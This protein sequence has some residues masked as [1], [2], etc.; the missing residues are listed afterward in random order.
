MTTL[1]NDNYAYN[2]MLK[3][4]S[5]KSRNT[6]TS[7]SK[8]KANEGAS[9]EEPITESEL[10]IYQTFKRINVLS[11]NSVKLKYL[12]L[13]FI[14]SSFS[15]FFE[16]A[17]LG[18]IIPLLQLAIGE[19]ISGGSL[20]TLLNIYSKFGIAESKIQLV[21][22]T[23]LL[24]L[25]S[26]ILKNVFS[27]ISKV[28]ISTMS[29]RVEHN[30]RTNI[31]AQLLKY[32]LLYFERSQIGNMSF[33]LERTK[34]L[35][36][37]IRTLSD[38]IEKL[39]MSVFY[40]GLMLYISWT[41]SLLM[42]LV[43]PIGYVVTKTIKKMVQNSS[44]REAGALRDI[45]NH[46]LR[47]FYSIGLIK[48]Y[49]TE[50]EE[51]NAFEKISRGVSETKIRANRI[52]SLAPVIQEPLV[53]LLVIL[54]AGVSYLLFINGFK[55]A[56][57]GFM[58]FFVVL[59]RFET[60]FQQIPPSLINLSRQKVMVASILKVF[61]S[62]PWM[63]IKSG[64]K[65]FKGIKKNFE[66]KNLSFRY[67]KNDPLVLQDINLKIKAGTTVAF[68]GETGSGKTTLISLLPRSFDYH[69]GEIL[70]DGVSLKKFD[71]R[72]LRHHFGIVRQNDVMFNM[73]FR[74][75]IVYGIKRKVS[76]KELITATKRAQIYD[77]I[78]S[79]KGGFNSMIG[80][81]GAD[82]SGGQRQRVSIARAIIRNS[83]ILI[84]DEATSALDSET[85]D[86]LQ[87]ALKEVFKGKTVFVVA[88]RLSTIQKA[89]V[90]VV[91]NKGR[92][93]EKGSFKQ[94]MKNQ[95]HFFHYWNLQ[96]RA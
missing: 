50:K 38:A 87:V 5:G 74:E 56:V 12:T 83:P 9:K 45:S 10:S 24:I 96:T 4:K 29:S 55:G 67:G 62:E 44:N 35:S 82:L 39:I 68:V 43:V 2:Y 15:S 76:E 59:K 92:I 36:Q 72:S 46:S 6:K 14:L 70:V 19:E 81:S 54:M 69:S 57:A 48:S 88:H 49:G 20:N 65:G 26:V 86:K 47:I 85:E 37:M 63:K 64:K 78:M 90:I 16:I 25:L 61:D 52:I 21:L 13:P 60:T 3:A 80:E 93:V 7:K 17:S 18:L 30:M 34:M 73:T 58:T 84:F 8:Q 23:A 95:D 91:L 89:D 1:L 27:Y 28:T 42:A 41:V 32:D 51:Y 11:G 75:N 31:M 77:F 40:F 79:H 94:L 53:T 22:I 71:L 66:I 33:I